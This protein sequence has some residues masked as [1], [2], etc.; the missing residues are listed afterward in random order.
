MAGLDELSLEELEALKKQKTASRGLDDMSIEELEALRDQ[1]AKTSSGG[2]DAEALKVG[3]EKGATFGARPFVAGIGG[4]AGY[5]YEKLKS[6]A[7]LTDLVS[8]FKE[9]FSGARTGAQEEQARLA[10]KSPGSFLAGELGG[11]LLMPGS[12]VKGIAGGAGG[13]QSAIRL[14]GAMGAGQALGESDDLKDAASKVGTGM[15]FGAASEG[16]VKGGSAF[17]NAIQRKF[18]ERSA[19]NAIKATGAMLKDFRALEGKGRTQKLGKY[20]VDKGV[21]QAGDTFESVGQKAST[22]KEQAGEALDSIY[23]YARNNIAGDI[24]GVNLK[25]DKEEIL[26]A[27][28]EALGDSEGAGAALARLGKYLEERASEYGDVVLDPRKA[29][30]IKSA[31]DETINYSRNPL[32][33]EPNIEK[34]FHAARQYV[35]RKIDDGIEA[36]G[37]AGGKDLLGALKEANLAYGSGAQAANMAKDRALR[38]GANKAFGLRQSILV[39]GG[40]GAGAIAGAATGDPEAAITGALKGAALGASLKTIERYGPAMLAQ[41]QKIAA[42]TIA[43]SSV[44]RRA[45]EKSPQAY[46]TLLKNIL[47][48]LAGGKIQAPQLETPR[49]PEMRLTEPF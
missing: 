39:G 20:L 18:E 34:A 42:D 31:M 36:I 17:K 40:A 22:L 10:E 45:I 14:G 8:N 16:L 6:G 3:L 4:G 15:L 1:K 2:L 28:K 33:K 5:A 46:Q 47:E 11:S 37:K 23:N 43:K 24:P 44:V 13:V 12:I 32:S 19:Q 41:G 9:G 27:A 25:R 26:A 38:E 48:G 29:N 49:E 30:N 35:S 21:V 7:P